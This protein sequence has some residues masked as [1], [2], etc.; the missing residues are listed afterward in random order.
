MSEDPHTQGI[1]PERV[2]G[3]T[4]RPGQDGAQTLE[5][6]LWFEHN[7]ET[8]HDRVDTTLPRM[9]TLP[10]SGLQ[11]LHAA[12]HEAPFPIPHERPP[13]D[14]LEPAPCEPAPSTQDTP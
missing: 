5:I 7:A 2:A 14:E 4:V 13:Q 8:P 10:L 9:Y 12:I 6:T 3:I 1:R 11:E